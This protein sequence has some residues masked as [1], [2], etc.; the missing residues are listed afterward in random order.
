[1]TTHEDE[2]YDAIHPA[3]AAYAE[4]FG[5]MLAESADRIADAMHD[6]AMDE[7]AGIKRDQA[8]REAQQDLL[9]EEE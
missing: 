4:S 7:A 6:A 2:L 9:G 1:M 5:L 3:A 8:A